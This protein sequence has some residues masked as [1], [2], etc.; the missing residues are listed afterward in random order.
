MTGA[1]SREWECAGYVLIYKEGDPDDLLNI[2]QVYL[3][4]IVCKMLEKNY[5]DDYTRT[6]SFCMMSSL[7][8]E[9]G[10]HELQTCLNSMKSY[11]NKEEKRGI[12]GLYLFGFCNSI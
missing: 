8:L 12:C 9:V 7:D 6:L 5:S 1:V 11:Q 4:S 10:E 2:R 3:T